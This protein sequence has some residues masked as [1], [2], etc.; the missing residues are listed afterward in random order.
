MNEPVE[1]KTS[2]LVIEDEVQI[3]RLLRA[4]LERNG[5]EVVEAPTGEAGIDAALQHQPEIILL[6]L[7]LPDVDGL[8][9]LRRLREWSHAPV[10]IVSVRGQEQDKITAL[11]SGANDYITKPFSTGEL[12]ARLR[13]VRRY[14]RPHLT[15]RSLRP[16]TCAS[17]YPP[18]PSK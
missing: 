13:V 17:I 8:A 2:L 15:P 1:R 4:C 7:G 3:R 12:L 6:D 9:V 5:Y 18:E 16:A 11:D 10:L 14:S